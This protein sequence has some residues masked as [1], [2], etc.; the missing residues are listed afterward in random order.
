MIRTLLLPP[1]LL[2]AACADGSVQTS[3]GAEYL[4]AAGPAP[5]TPDPVIL[6]RGADGAEPLSTPTVS[7]EA[8][9]RQAAAVEPLLTLPARLGIARIENGRLTLIPAREAAIWDALRARRPEL[10]APA[11]VDPFIAE[12]ALR[13]ATPTEALRRRRDSQDMLTRIRVGAAR[14]HMDA[15]L[16]YEVGRRGAA[17]GALSR[18]RDLSVLGGQ[19][20]AASED[21][22]Q[23]VARAVLIDVRNG[24]PYAAASAQAD[25]PE[26]EWWQDDA[27]SR[28]TLGQATVAATEALIP[29]VEAQVAALLARSAAR[30]R[31]PGG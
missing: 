24:Y 26:A 16:I 8:M 28:A 2:L 4:R 9:V 29:Q 27:A 12:Q 15:V 19:P 23:A 25:L 22:A 10:G 7:T 14:Q 11:T 6:T 31:A 21:E 18:L 30:A 13:S 3:S 17:K 5:S 1:L 20:L